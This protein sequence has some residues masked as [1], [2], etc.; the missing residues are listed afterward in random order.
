MIPPWE[1]SV[2]RLKEIEMTFPE[3]LWAVEYP[4]Q[5]M[6]FSLDMHLHPLTGE[7]K[8]GLLENNLERCFIYPSFWLLREINTNFRPCVISCSKTTYIFFVFTF[9]FEII[10][11]SYGS[12]KNSTEFHIAFF[13][14][15]VS[16]LSNI[17][18]LWMLLP[19]TKHKILPFR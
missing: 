15:V 4:M 19:C 17:V 3:V 2:A 18:Y 14:E 5:T 8:I 1:V 12:C 10:L 7:V 13:L 16:M 6:S 11:D 9:Y